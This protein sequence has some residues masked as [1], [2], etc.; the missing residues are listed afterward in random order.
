MGD[1]PTDAGIRTVEAEINY[2]L[3]G[4]PAINRRF[5]SAGVEVNT[6][7]YASYPVQVRDARPIADR[8]TLDNSG[9]TLLAH[10]SAVTD[11]MNKEE[12]DRIYPDES[13]EAI[14]A[15]TGADFVAPMGWMVRTAGD[16]T[17]YRKPVKGYTHKG[18]VQPPAGEAHID[19]SPQR[20]DMNA[21]AVYARVR[22]NGPGYR[23][24]IYSSFWRAFSEPPQDWPL[25]VCEA[26][27]V[28][29]D[30]GVENVLVIADSIPEGE[31][32]FAPIAGEDKLPA[33]AIF[34]YNPAHRWWYVSNMTRD[35]ALLLKFHDSDRSVA[36]RTPH[37]AFRDTSFENAN[38]RASI[39]VRSVAFFE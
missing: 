28:A 17:K 7:T 12:V 2:L 13:A 4:G 14:K 29:P 20:A 36:W 16:L 8:F 11:F 19:T 25:A 15:A 30:E 32:L 34:H 6:G 9:F 10:T 38:I 27:S 21:R 24:F 23:R 33:A 35:E 18:G 5:V 31:G 37:T 22:P 3:P 26:G 39:E 1:A